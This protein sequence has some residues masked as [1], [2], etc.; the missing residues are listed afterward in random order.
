M[1]A[2]AYAQLE[3]RFHRIA[4]LNH[5]LSVLHWDMAT[6]MP[7]GG[8]DA[9]SEQM[10]AIKVVAHELLVDPAV[11]ELLGGASS[12]DARRAANLRE[13]RRRWLHATAVPGDLVEALSRA[14]SACERWR[15]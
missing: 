14:C 7:E 3:T 10:A 6:M 12:D 1:A 8:M 9:R 13:M 4:S 15:R 11:G 5:A 2:D